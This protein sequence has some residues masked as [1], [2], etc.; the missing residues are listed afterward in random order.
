MTVF[1]DVKRI[2]AASAATSLHVSFLMG[3]R[4]PLKFNALKLPSSQL[5]LLSPTFLVCICVSGLTC[6]IH[7]SLSCFIFQCPLITSNKE[8]LW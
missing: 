3:F 5:P 1:L 7:I 8:V 2:V 4:Y 6:V